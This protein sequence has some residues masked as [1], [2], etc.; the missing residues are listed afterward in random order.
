MLQQVALD[1]AQGDRERL[2]LGVRVTQR[3]DELE[4]PVADGLEVFVD[5]TRAL[6]GEDQRAY[7]EETLVSSSSIGGSSGDA[8]RLVED[9]VVGIH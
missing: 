6:G 8:D 3:A 2:L 9:G 1:L 5:L 7:F 4:D